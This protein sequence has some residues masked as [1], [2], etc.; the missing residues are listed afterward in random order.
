MHDL[1]IAEQERSGRSLVALARDIGVGRLALRQWCYG[2]KSPRPQRRGRL[3][4][5]LHVSIERLR[6][7][8]ESTLEQRRQEGAAR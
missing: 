6:A 4:D 5:E 3:A 1:V 8:L 7:A 2:E